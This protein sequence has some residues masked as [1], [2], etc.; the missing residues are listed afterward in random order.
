MSLRVL[1]EEIGGRVT[2]VDREAH[3]APVHRERPAQ[4][5]INSLGEFLR[6]HGSGMAPRD[7]TVARHQDERRT[8]LDAEAL[9]PG[10]VLIIRGRERHIP[11]AIGRR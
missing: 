8:F 4:P 2:L 11:L 10:P 3:L 6:G 7:L 5:R 9:G 1:E